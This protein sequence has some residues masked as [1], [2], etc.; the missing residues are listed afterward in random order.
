MTQNRKPPAYQEYAASTLANRQFRLMNLLERGLLYTLRLECW[1]N[2][3]IPAVADELAKYLGCDVREIQ[4]GLTNGVRSFFVEENGL[5]S[6]PEL[7]NYRQHLEARKTKQSEGGK[8]GAAMTNKSRK[9]ANVRHSGTSAG[10]S[11]VPRRVGVESL[12]QLNPV[13]QSQ[14]QSLENDLNAE[15]KNNYDEVD[16]LAKNKYELRRG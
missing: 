8:Q 15:W 5:F 16:G 7:D 3:Q 2:S 14:A 1:E 12:V 13:K 10:R 11:Q 9:V 6:C 4:Q